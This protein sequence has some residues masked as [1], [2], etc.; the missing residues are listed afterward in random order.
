MRTNDSARGDGDEPQGALVKLLEEISPQEQD[1]DTH[2]DLAQHGLLLFDGKGSVS[3]AGQEVG[4]PIMVPLYLRCGSNHVG[5]ILGVR[6]SHTFES[7]VSQECPC[8]QFVR[9]NK[10]SKIAW[11]LVTSIQGAGSPPMVR[12]NQAGGHH[13]PFLFLKISPP[14]PRSDGTFTGVHR[15][16]CDQ[17]HNSPSG[18]SQAGSMTSH[19]EA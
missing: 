13:I 5:G 8:L 11:W 2:I 18:T 19:P 9:Q 7:C 10:I 15:L 1:Q 17:E 14:S 12:G 6:G 16:S 3:M 4:C